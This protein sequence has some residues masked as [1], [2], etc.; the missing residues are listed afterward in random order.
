MSQ[1]ELDPQQFDASVKNAAG[2]VVVDFFATWCGPCKAL[3]PAIEKLAQDF[4]GQAN[5]YKIDTD[6]GGDIAS[7]FGIRGVPTIIFF[8]DGKEANRI[9]GSAPYE[10][11]AA[12]LK[13]IL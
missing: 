4:A 11:L 1:L 13:A 3:A 2:A 12:T 8:K 7:G 10:K 9:V 5:V 6:K